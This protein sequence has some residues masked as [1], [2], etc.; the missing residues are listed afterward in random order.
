MRMARSSLIISTTTSRRRPHRNSPPH[1][2][3]HPWTKT[4]GAHC[5]LA[6]ARPTTHRWPN[7]S[8]CRRSICAESGSARWARLPTT[9][10]RW[11]PRRQSTSGSSR[12]KPRTK[13][14]RSSRRTSRHADGSSCMRRRRRRTGCATRASCDST[15]RA[16]IHPI[17]RRWTNPS[18]RQC[19]RS[20][21]RPQDAIR[22]SCPRLAAVSDSPTSSRCCRYRSSR[23]PRSITTMPS[24]RR[25]RT[26]ACRIS[27][28]QSRC[29]P[30]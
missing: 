22:S 2:R 20:S 12:I 8:C 14:A 7:A 21:R 16:A 23:C 11:T 4:C 24:M 15:G 9:R 30:D 6:P 29:S 13:S 28:T 17:A 1:V 3:C 19:A 5:C 18:A 25:M 27:G 10:C 26:S